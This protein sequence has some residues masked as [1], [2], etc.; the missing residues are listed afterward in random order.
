MLK[1]KNSLCIEDT[2]RFIK[3]YYMNRLN[4]ANVLD[5][6]YSFVTDTFEIL[7]LAINDEKILEHQK[8]TIHKMDIVNLMERFKEYNPWIF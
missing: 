8:D 7:Y 5:I 1:I 3:W 6:K 2:Q 4:V